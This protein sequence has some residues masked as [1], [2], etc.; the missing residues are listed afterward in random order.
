MM[1]ISKKDLLYSQFN[2]RIS[3]QPDSDN[4]GKS[5]G[6]EDVQAGFQEVSGLSSETSI[7]EY[8]AGNNNKNAPRKISNILKTTNITFNRGVMRRLDLCKWIDESRNGS[9]KQLKNINIKLMSEDRLTVAQ[10][11]VLKNV[12]L[13]KHTG[14][15]LNSKGTDLAI[16]E[17]VVSAEHIEVLI[18]KT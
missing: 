5:I 3:W 11:W 9:K 2:F 13:M 14:P 17:L 6:V 12:R 16:E 7:T 1:S 10:E 4:E 8:R 15:S 18:D